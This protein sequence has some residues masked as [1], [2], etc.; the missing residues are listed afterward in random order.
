[1]R[2]PS[3]RQPPNTITNQIIFLLC[4]Q[5]FSIKVFPLTSVCEVIPNHFWFDLAKFQS[6]FAQTFYFYLFCFCSNFKN[7]QYASVYRVRLQKAQCK[8]CSSQTDFVV[9]VQLLSHVQLFGTPR[10]VGTRLLCPWDVPGNN[11]GVGCHFLLQGIFSTQGWKPPL[12]HWQG[13]S[14][15]RSHQGSPSKLLFFVIHCEGYKRGMK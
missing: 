10:T 12:L 5:L 7:F 14:L 8:I 15:P 11:T 6:I 9:I 2:L 1:M 4:V 13:D 3:I